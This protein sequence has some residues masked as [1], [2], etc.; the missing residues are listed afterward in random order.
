M[1]L[2]QIRL[3]VSDFSACFRFYRDVLG[4]RP[5]VDD[6]HGPYAKFTASEG[7]CAIALQ[8]RAHFEA[9]FSELRGLGSSSDTALI[10]LKVEALDAY[11]EELTARGATILQSPTTQW[12]RLRVA[13]L[14]DPEDNLI[15][16][17][18]WLA[19][20]SGRDSAH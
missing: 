4:L 10:V 18:Q 16:L 13:Y 6:E 1:E 19:T 3:L 20:A 7:Q 5:Q 15:E 9:S 12:E 8:S 2:V 17:Q 11:C 14:R